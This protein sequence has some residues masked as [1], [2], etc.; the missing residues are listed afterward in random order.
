MR[1]VHR[2][3]ASLSGRKS[4]SVTLTQS[5]KSSVNGCGAQWYV[6]ENERPYERTWC[7]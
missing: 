3:R 5:L 7:G 6:D 1:Y 2:K 4:V